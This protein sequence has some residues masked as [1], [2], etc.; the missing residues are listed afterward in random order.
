MSTT[1]LPTNNPTWGFSGTIGAHADLSETW[2]LA[3]TAIAGMTGCTAEAV[4]DFL[5]SRHG[6]HFAEDVANGLFAGLSLSAAIDAAV[7]RRMGW[8]IGKR[9]EREH[10][11][12]RDLPYLTGWVM[13][14]EI[15]SEIAN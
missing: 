3:M 9:V 7:E 1:I 6:R 4:R 12:P 13:N 5:D 11:I 15:E 10:G 2:A 8:T 14:C